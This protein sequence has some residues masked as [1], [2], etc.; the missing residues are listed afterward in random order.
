VHGSTGEL[1]FEVKS[2][3]ISRWDFTV[4]FD[5][6]LVGGLEGELEG[7]HAHLLASEGVEAVLHEEQGSLPSQGRGTRCARGH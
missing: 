2:A 1:P 4:V 7:L 6:A 3:L 5:D